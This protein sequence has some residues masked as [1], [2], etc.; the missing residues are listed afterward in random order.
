M[1]GIATHGRPRQQLCHRDMIIRSRK[2]VLG[3][4]PPAM[5]GG[6]RGCRHRGVVHRARQES[7]DRRTGVAHIALDATRGNVSCALRQPRP[8]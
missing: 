7:T 2:C 5:A 6:A 1:T 4:I 8:S 3:D